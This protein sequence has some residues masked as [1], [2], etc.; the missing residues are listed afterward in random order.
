MVQS[1]YSSSKLGVTSL[2]S[3]IVWSHLISGSAVLFTQ[4]TF[5]MNGYMKFSATDRSMLDKKYKEIIF[6][7]SLL[8]LMIIL[9]GW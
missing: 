3:T 8:K 7:S 1:Y 2:F 6:V 9:K 5:F 4:Y